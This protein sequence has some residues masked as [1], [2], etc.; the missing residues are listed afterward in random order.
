MSST[1][2]RTSLFCGT[3]F[4]MGNDSSVFVFAGVLLLTIVAVSVSVD[5]LRSFNFL[6]VSVFDAVLTSVTCLSTKKVRWFV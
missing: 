5:E 2:D 6:R 4:C 1:I 3:S